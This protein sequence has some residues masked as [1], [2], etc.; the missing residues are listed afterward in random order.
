VDRA[1]S[2]GG[3]PVLVA[4][5]TA[6]FLLGAALGVWGAFLVP[7]RLFGSVEGLADVVGFAGPL[8][9]GYLGGLGLRAAPAAIVPGLGWII[10]FLTLGYSRGGDVVV[11]GSLATDHGVAVVG[12]LYFFSG[13][14]GILVAGVVTARRLRRAPDA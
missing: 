11:P 4:A 1:A 10:A 12:T 9:T 3:T 7:L 13:L 5:Y 8:V 14:V 6:L 2:D